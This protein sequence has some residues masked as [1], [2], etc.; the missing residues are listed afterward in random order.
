MSADAVVI[1]VSDRAAAGTRSDESGPL[2]ARL[3]GD[4]G[5]PSRVVVVPDEPDAVAG[6]VR[7]AAADGARIIVTTGGT[8]LG[9]RDV[10]PQAIEPLLRLTLPGV[11]ERVRAAGAVPTAALSRGI[12]GVVGNAVVVTLAGSTGAVRDGIPVVL[13]VAEHAIAQLDGG[14]HA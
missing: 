2:A 8:G 12:A 6:A 3:L 10:T 1:T 9:P 13:S 4:A 5:W 11:A 7:D 14:D